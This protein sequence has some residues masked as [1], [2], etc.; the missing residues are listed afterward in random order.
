VAKPAA[1]SS[2]SILGVNPNSLSM[3][4]LILSCAARIAG[5]LVRIQPRGAITLQWIVAE[6]AAGKP[7]VASGKKWLR[8]DRSDIFWETI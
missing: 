1:I 2:R 3:R 5:P 7:S 6:I 8:R 4:A